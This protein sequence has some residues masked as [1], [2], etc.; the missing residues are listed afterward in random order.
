MPASGH[1]GA[2]I[3]SRGA[4]LSTA[5]VSSDLRDGEN[6]DEWS[7]PGTADLITDAIPFD[8]GALDQAIDQ[9]FAVLR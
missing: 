5:H 9:F 1:P 8:R 2:A 6:R 4:L 3:T 7:R